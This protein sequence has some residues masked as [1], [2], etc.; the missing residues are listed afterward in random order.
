M[1]KP[2]ICEDKKYLFL[3]VS[4]FISNSLLGLIKALKNKKSLI[5]FFSLLPKN[6]PKHLFQKYHKLFVERKNCA[7]LKVQT[8]ELKTHELLERLEEFL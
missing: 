3:N 7:S 1:C 6:S 2:I 5:F 8:K 4:I